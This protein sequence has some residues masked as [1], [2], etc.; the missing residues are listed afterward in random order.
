MKQSF[1]VWT[2]GWTSSACSWGRWL[3]AKLT[4]EQTA[5]IARALADPRRFAIFEQ[6]ARA[7]QLPCSA[8]DVHE[9]ISP[10]TIS[11][12]L[13]ELAEAGLIEA[14]REGRTMRLSVKRK[15]WKAYV[16]RLGQF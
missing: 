1:G 9:A 16:K 8:L 4:D 6:I 14:E 12:H 15:A 7:G 5:S 3:V 11:H 13:K 2:R 10:A